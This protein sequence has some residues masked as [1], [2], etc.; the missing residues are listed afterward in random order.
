M[1]DCFC[2]E[3]DHPE[4]EEQIGLKEDRFHRGRQIASMIYD[5]F[6]V[7]GAHNTVLDEADL[8]TIALRN[9]DVQEFDTRWDEILL[10]VTKISPDLDDFLETW[11]KLRNRE[12]HQ[13]KTTVSELYDMEIHQKDVDARLSNI[14]NDGGKEVRNS[15]CE[16]LT[17]E[18]R[19][20]K[21]EQ[22][23]RFAGVNV[24]VERGQG[25]CHQWKAK[26]QCSRGDKCSFWHDEVKFATPTSETAPPSEPPT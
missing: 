12:S 2:S 15:D 8:F 19:E 7:T 4:L 3:Q 10:S 24:G 26:G 18:M 22:W 5:Y 21:Q 6:R 11:Y 13:L 20:L 16:T 14:E 1:Q 23:S 25:E 17:P 9:D